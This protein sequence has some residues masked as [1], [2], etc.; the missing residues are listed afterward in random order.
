MNALCASCAYF[1][2]MDG[3]ALGQCRAEPPK[4]LFPAIPL[5]PRQIGEPRWTF[6]SSVWPIV[7]KDD[8]CGCHDERESGLELAGN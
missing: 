2:P 8:W 1:A 3:Q 4:P 6:G 7:K 5:D